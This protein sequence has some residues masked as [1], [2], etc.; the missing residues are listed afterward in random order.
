MTICNGD[1]MESLPC[2][3]MNAERGSASAQPRTRAQAERASRHVYAAVRRVLLTLYLLTYLLV[4]ER[5]PSAPTMAPTYVGLQMTTA[6]AGPPA[7]NEPTAR[8]TGG[9]RGGRVALPPGPT[10]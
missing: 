7:L 1:R 3:S 4:H 8:V 6:I 5:K 2:G 9:D 10:G